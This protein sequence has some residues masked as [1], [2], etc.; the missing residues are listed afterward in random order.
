[1]AILLHLEALSLSD[2][3]ELP[4]E[5]R[6]LLEF[7]IGSLKQVDYDTQFYWVTAVTQ[8]QVAVL[9]A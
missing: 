1:M 8:A 7:D 2:Q 4:E 9:Y 5:S 6:F 3:N